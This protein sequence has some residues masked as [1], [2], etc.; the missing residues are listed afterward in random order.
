LGPTSIRPGDRLSFT[1]PHG[2]ATL[3]LLRFHTRLLTTDS[4]ELLFSFPPHRSELTSPALVLSAGIPI[5]T[6]P[7]T[8]PTPATQTHQQSALSDSEIIERLI[9][10]LKS[11]AGLKFVRNEAT[12]SPSDAQAFLRHKLRRAQ[13]AIGSVMQFIDQNASKSS[14][15]GQEYMVLFPDGRRIPA[16]EY[17]T[18]E[19]RRLQAEQ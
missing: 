15:T 6:S 19:L 13:P 5:T 10:G 8:A 11:P 2:A 3:D 18:N 12:H 16:R 1:T 17:W 14:T 4:A 9:D 7:A